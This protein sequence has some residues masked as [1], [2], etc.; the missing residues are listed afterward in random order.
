MEQRTVST[1]EVRRQLSGLLL[2]VQFKGERVT[3]TRN[4][5]PV[6]VLGPHVEGEAAT[7]A[8]KRTTRGKGQ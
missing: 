7:Q 1:V 4:G 2:A 6:A 3:I 8:G 5:H